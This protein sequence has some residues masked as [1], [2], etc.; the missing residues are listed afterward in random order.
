MG[1]RKSLSFSSPHPS[2]F[3]SS[4][5]LSYALD[6][7]GRAMLDIFSASGRHVRS[8][9][10]EELAAGTHHTDW[11]GRDTHGRELSAGVYFV[12]LQLGGESRHGRLVRSR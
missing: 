12:R 3:R 4:T 10:D 2:P 8:L 1:R 11:D 6:A 7:P 9:V 5:T